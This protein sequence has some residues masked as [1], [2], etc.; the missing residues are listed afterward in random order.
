MWIFQH[1][2]SWISILLF[3]ENKNKWHIVLE[4]NDAQKIYLLIHIEINSLQKEMNGLLQITLW[5]YIYS[6]AVVMD[7]REV[8]YNL[9]NNTR[10]L[11]WLLT[12]LSSPSVFH[13]CY[14][15]RALYSEAICFTLV[16][17]ETLPTHNYYPYT[18]NNRYWLL[19]HNKLFQNKKLL[20]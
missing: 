16:M 18:N 14:W 17:V 4:N 2:V 6:K 15:R 8:V 19:L 13:P 9:E 5:F 3:S 20:E 12:K 10:Q 7:R 1:V 11:D